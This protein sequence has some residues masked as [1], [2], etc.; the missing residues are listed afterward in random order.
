MS[1]FC[2]S[3]LFWRQKWVTGALHDNLLVVCRVSPGRIIVVLLLTKYAVPRQIKPGI[4]K[5]TTSRGQRNLRT[6]HNFVSCEEK[7]CYRTVSLGQ[8]I[9]PKK[10]CLVLEVI[11][12]KLEVAAMRMKSN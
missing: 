6:V 10:Y 9:P 4:L 1:K 2:A 5:V 3:K 11:K 8:Q 7:G 12:L